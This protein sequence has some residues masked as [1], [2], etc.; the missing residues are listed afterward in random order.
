MKR[1][2]YYNMSPSDLVALKQELLEQIDNEPIKSTVKILKE[3]LQK[4][5]EALNEYI[6]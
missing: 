1:L 2:D 5:Q 3:Q 4:V 6:D